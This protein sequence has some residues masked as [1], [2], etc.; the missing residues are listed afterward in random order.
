MPESREA[1]AVRATSIGQEI[2]QLRM[3]LKDA[4][5]PFLRG[6]VRGLEEQLVLI[7]TMLNESPGEDL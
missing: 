4:D 3:L 5:M 6:M 1:L 2:Y 7:V